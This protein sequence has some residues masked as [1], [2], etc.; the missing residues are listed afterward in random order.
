MNVETF[1]ENAKVM[2]KG[3]IT[4]PKDVREA[5]GVNSGDRVYFLVEGKSVRIVNAAVYAMRILQKEMAGE[6]EQADLT[7]EAAILEM[8]KSARTA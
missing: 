3:Q 6:A 2:S 7:S 4:I 8:V 5:L 1:V